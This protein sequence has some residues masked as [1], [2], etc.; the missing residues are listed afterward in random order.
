MVHENVIKQIKFYLGKIY[1][2]MLV[3][4]RQRRHGYCAVTN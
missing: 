2:S 3:S 1:Y 4:V